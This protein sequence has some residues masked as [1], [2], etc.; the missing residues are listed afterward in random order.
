[1]EITGKIKFI[2][3]TKPQKNG[4][5]KREIVVTTQEQYPQHI[6]IEFVQEKCDVINGYKV[7][8]NVKVGINLRGRE[9]TDPEGKIKYFNS[10]QGWRIDKLENNTAQV[11]ASIEAQTVPSETATADDDLPF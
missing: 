1:M 4:F 9:W 6:K 10:V 2:D 11:K 8:D 3:E 7:G 5:R